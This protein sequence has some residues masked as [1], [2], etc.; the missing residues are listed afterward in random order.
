MVQHSSFPIEM[1]QNQF[2]AKFS[3]EAEEQSWG[4]TAPW[5]RAGWPGPAPL[6]GAGPA[7]APWPGQR[8]P[9]F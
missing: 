9:R 4:I 2:H 5:K 7:I 8:P 3:R 1:T 6:L